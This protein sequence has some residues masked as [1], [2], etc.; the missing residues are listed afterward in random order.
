ML[1]SQELFRKP[2]LSR[3]L[4]WNAPIKRCATKDLVPGGLSPSTKS[5]VTFTTGSSI[6]QPIAWNPST[7]WPVI[8][9]LCVCVVCVCVCAHVYVFTY[10]LTCVCTHACVHA[11]THVCVC[12]R[13]CICV[14]LCVNVR[15]RVFYLLCKEGRKWLLWTP[16]AECM[17]LLHCS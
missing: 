6:H 14:H 8:Y 11:C 17:A 16:E 9:V 2:P 15:V 5:L 1:N 7:N 13:V 10:M 4:F 12:M 3:D